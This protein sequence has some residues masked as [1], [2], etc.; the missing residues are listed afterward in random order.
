MQSAGAGAIGGVTM[1]AASGIEIALWDLCGRILQTPVCNLLGG[2]FRDRVR[3]YRTLQ[4]VEQRRRSRRLA[5]PGAGGPRRK[6]GLDRLQVPGRRR[7]PQSR[8]RVPGARPRPLR[9]QPHAQGLPPHRQGHGDGPRDA[10]P[11]RRFRHRMPLA[12]RHA[13]R[14]PPRRA[15]WSTSSPM[16]LEDPV[17]PDN[18]EAMARVTQSI[19]VPVCTG[20]NLYGRQGFRKLIEMQATSR[21]AHRHS[22]I[23]R[24][25]RIEEDLRPGRPVLHLDRLPQSREP[26]G[27]HR[28]RPRRRGHARVPHPRTGE[29]DRLVAGPGRPRRSVLGRTATSR[30]RTSPATA[31]RSIPT[32]PRRIWRPAKPGGASA[33]PGRDCPD[34][35]RTASGSVNRPVSIVNRGISSGSPDDFSA[36][37]SSK[38]RLRAGCPGSASRRSRAISSSHRHSMIRGVSG[39]AANRR[40]T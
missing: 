38:L 25:A 26:G 2:R 10:R 40:S 9:P 35:T 30:F 8:S 33:D 20:E 19:N 12:L 13:G 24:A 23:R 36:R 37:Y 18:I 17:P 22:E 1:T 7:S 31:S 27:H 15:N 21:R 39:S 6:V 11:G 5:R 14:D 29:V 28:V 34:S 16:W 4:A 3:F 32:S